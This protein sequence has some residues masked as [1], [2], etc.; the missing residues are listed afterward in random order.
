MSDS[1]EVIYHRHHITVT[2]AAL[3]TLCLL[4]STRQLCIRIE[5][6]AQSQ[7]QPALHTIC[8]NPLPILLS[9]AH[10]YHI[11]ALTAQESSSCT[12]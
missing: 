3:A 7:Q 10:R 6:E 8:A 9:S 2:A 12:T 5:T 4:Y 11:T 1:E